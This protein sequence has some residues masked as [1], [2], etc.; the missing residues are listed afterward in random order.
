MTIL[1]ERINKIKS[2]G[3]W[4]VLI[5]PT[6]FETRRIP[7]FSGA[8]QIIDSSKVSLRGWDYPYWQDSEAKNVGEYVEC[9]VDWSQYI[10]Y[11]RFY[12]SGQ[13]MH[14]FA[15]HEDHIDVEKSLGTS[16]PPRPK[17]SGYLS[18][19]GATLIVTEIFEFAARL[20][21][22]DILSPAAFVSIGLYNMYDHQLAAFNSRR[23]MPDR[24]V[25]ESS[26]PIVFETQVSA[27]DLISK[28]DELALDAV[29]EIFEHFNW[30]NPPRDI[31]A[32]DQ[33]RLRERR[34]H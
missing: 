15:V 3:Y 31:L 30:N 14:L 33:R 5:R 17:R 28:T 12:R 10:E 29:V 21:S 20:A 1:E 18:F 8:R 32:E 24:Y 9:S 16:Y 2:K 11:W 6:T 27:Q 22:K 4:R 25:R 26:E 23:L 19:I 13:F 7:T 34:L